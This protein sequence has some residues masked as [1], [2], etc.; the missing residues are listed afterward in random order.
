MP[1]GPNRM[2]GRQPPT[3]P[4]PG[5]ATEPGVPRGP[6]Q[7]L[8]IDSVTLPE[9]FRPP[10]EKDPTME[11]DRPLVLGDELKSLKR[12]LSRYQTN[13]RKALAS[14]PEKAVIRNGIKYRLALLCLRENRLEVSKLRE[15]LLRD[16]NSAAS[17]MDFPKPEGVRDFRKFVLQELVSQ[18]TPLLETQNFHVRL[19]IA[20]LLGELDLTLENDKLALKQEAFFQANV[21]LVKAIEDPQQPQAIKVAAVNGLFRIL[22]Q[23]NPDVLTRTKIAQA[24]VNAL[25]DKTLHPWYQMRLVGALSAVDIELDE[26]RTPFVVNALLAILNDPAPERK[27][28]VKAQAAKSLGR[29]PL[30]ASADPPSVTRAVAAF[31]LK[32]GKAAQQDPPRDGEDPKW[33]SEF[34]KLYLAFMPFDDKDLT[35]DKKNK[36]GL[37]NNTAAQAKAAYTL[38]VPLVNTI[39]NRQRLTAQQIKALEAWVVPTAEP[40]AIQNP[41]SGPQD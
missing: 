22:R 34:V 5:Q 31:A 17:A 38:I 26:Q 20:I 21:P 37:L 36:A 29:V 25:K 11:I 16:I 24:I 15:D 10:A 3:G 13:L 4:I 19:Q 1:G 32:L 41:A 27:W 2:G 7:E 23:G 14:D 12:D 30:P 39:L 6:A 18:A 33:R 9:G 8:K 40:A 35:A 28:Y